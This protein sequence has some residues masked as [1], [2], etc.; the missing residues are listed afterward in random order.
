VGVLDSNG[1]TVAVA[2]QSKREHERVDQERIDQE[3]I[4][5]ERID[6]ERDANGSAADARAGI[7]QDEESE[8]DS[9]EVILYGDGYLYDGEARPAAIC[10]VDSDGVGWSYFVNLARRVREVVSLTLDEL[11]N[12]IEVTRNTNVLIRFH[13]TDVGSGLTRSNSFVSRSRHTLEI[14][15]LSVYH[16]ISQ[17]GAGSNSVLAVRLAVERV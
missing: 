6:Q 10:N 4:D 2:I 5:Q 12:G 17:L 11:L 7:Y 16:V 3:R 1:D 15:G 8:D 13:I 14:A 9:E